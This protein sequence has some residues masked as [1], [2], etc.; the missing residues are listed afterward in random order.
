MLKKM[1][2]AQKIIGVI[3]LVGLISVATIVFLVDDRIRVGHMHVTHRGGIREQ[4]IELVVT[5]FSDDFTVH[6]TGSRDLVKYLKGA[7]KR[8][9]IDRGVIFTSNHL[10]VRQKLEE[11]RPLI[12]ELPNRYDVREEFLTLVDPLGELHLVWVDAYVI[13]YNP[14]LI[15]IKDVPTTWEELANFE[16]PISWPTKGCIGTW[17]TKA[18]FSYLGEEN[19]TKLSNNAKIAGKPNK[20]SQAVI[21]GDVAVGIGTLI[22]TDLRDEKVS[23]IWPEDGA[24]AKPSFLVIA[25]NAKEHHKKMADTLMSVEAAKMYASDFNLAPA[26]AGSAVP[27]LITENNFNF[28]FIPSVD[29]ICRKSDEIINNILEK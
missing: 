16:Q 13:I 17:G 12:A 2:K 8:E 26:L 5:E 14:S 29:I 1:S 24:I 22:N 23:I 28:V 10:K 20:A 27:M 25:N 18:F 3:I 4:M 6:D 15:D 11:A 9:E 21:D 19:F 7:I